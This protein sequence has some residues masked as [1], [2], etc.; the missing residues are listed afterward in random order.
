MHAFFNY[1]WIA[2]VMTVVSIIMT[3]TLKK[4]IRT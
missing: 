3:P 2:V 4:L 1:A